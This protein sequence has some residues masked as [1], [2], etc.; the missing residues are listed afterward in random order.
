[1]I[2][3]RRKMLNNDQWELKL[4]GLTMLHLEIEADVTLDEDVAARVE[5]R[6]LEKQ[7]RASARKRMLETDFTSRQYEIALMALRKES[8]E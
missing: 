3:A 2:N 7:A 6:K 1:M 8:N 5:R 4:R